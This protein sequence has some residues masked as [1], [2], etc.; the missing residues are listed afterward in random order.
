[1]KRIVLHAVLILL[2]VVL[3]L[4]LYWTLIG[5]FLPQE[6]FAFHYGD[7]N[8]TPAWFT[9]NPS[10][11]QY[12]QLL[13][14]E[15]W[16]CVGF[17][18]SFAVSL[19][20]AAAMT[21]LHLL[22]VPVLGFYLAKQNNRFVRVLFFFVIL[23]MLAPLQI[24]MTPT[25]ILAKQLKIDN[26]WW[27]ILLPSAVMPFGVF[28]TRQFMRGLP[29]EILDAARLDTNSVLSVLYYLVIPFSIPALCTLL[30]L[31]FSECYGMIEQPLILLDPAKSVMPLSVE[32]NS[33][34]RLFP[35]VIFAA[36]VLFVFPCLL[37]YLCVRKPMVRTMNELTLL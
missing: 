27:A 32:M 19:L 29:D 2:A 25:L 13:Y 23:T 12:V 5:S 30:M 18:Q 36:S 35:N 10:L 15:D 31:C 37:L 20:S 14:P 3:I 33:V 8:R 4:P 6:K 1:M 24:T 16:M 21:A 17:L 34:Y 11:E 7:L 28:L 22:T 9:L 26:S